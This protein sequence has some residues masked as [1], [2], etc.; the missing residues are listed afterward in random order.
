MQ[1]HEMAK[2]AVEGTDMT[3]KPSE[4]TVRAWARLVRTQQIVLEA[5]ERD[6]KAAGF[7]PLAWYDVLWA[8]VRAPE[9][10]LRPFEIEQQILLAQYNL[11]RLLDRLERESLIARKPCGDDRRG[12]WV[13][14]TAAGRALRERMWVAYAKAIQR[15]V[16]D[17][18]DSAAAVKLAELLGRLGDGHP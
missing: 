10:Q 17:K 6:L 13:A 2:K 12:Q 8:L 16:G 9:G 18:L 15:H 3:R 1:M 5:V 11:S 4:E 14:I 7:P